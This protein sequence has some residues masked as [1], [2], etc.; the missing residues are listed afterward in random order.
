MKA[1]YI[2]Q[3]G[4]ADQLTLGELTKPEIADNQVL[5]K[6]HGAAVNPVD[7]MVREGFLQSSGEHQLPLIL[8]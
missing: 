4:N 2:E 8:G 7:W 5:I 6:V 3:Y 1:I